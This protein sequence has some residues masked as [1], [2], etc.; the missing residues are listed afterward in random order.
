MTVEDG[1]CGDAFGDG[2]LVFGGDVDVVVHLADVYVDEDEVFCEQFSVGLLMEVD[3]EDLAVAAP[4]AAEVEDD[5]FV[6]AACLGDGGCDVGGGV[7]GGGVD[8]LADEG[9]IVWSVS[10]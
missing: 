6:L 4:V 2:D 9:R 10:L 8:V 3:V 5:A 7:R 1:E